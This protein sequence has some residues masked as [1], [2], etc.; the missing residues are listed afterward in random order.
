MAG[1]HPR[2]PPLI[3]DRVRKVIALAVDEPV[4]DLPE[5][6]S[7]EDVMRWDSLRHLILMVELEKEFGLRIAP[8]TI[9][10]LRSLSAIVSFV[11]EQAR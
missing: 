11:E 2:R 4:D 6:P 3:E 9:P 10:R 8:E 1:A 7:P 5:N